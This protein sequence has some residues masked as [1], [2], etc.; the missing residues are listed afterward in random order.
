MGFWVVF[1]LFFFFSFF[2]SFFLFFSFRRAPFFLGEISRSGYKC[3][4]DVMMRGRKLRR[5]GGL[6]WRETKKRVLRLRTR[7]P[8]EDAR[9][10]A[11]AEPEPQPEPEPEPEPQPEPEPAPEPKP[12]PAPAPVP[13]PNRL[14]TNIIGAY[15]TR[16]GTGERQVR[17][18]SAVSERERM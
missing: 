4:Y 5:M 11:R 12:K 16:L 3:L 1:F 18:S 9:P 7:G 8:G 10:R 13:I 17:E 15:F 14:R 6:C 2:L